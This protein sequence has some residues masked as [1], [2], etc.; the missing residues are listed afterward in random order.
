M[1]DAIGARHLSRLIEYEGKGI[2]AFLDMLLTA[3]NPLDL[4]RRNEDDGCVSPGEFLVRRLKLSHL[5]SAVGSPGS[6]YENE[7]EGLAPVVREPDSP[8][9][10]GW[11]LENRRGVTD[12]QSL[13]SAFEHGLL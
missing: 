1:V 6:A 12:I 10:R 3:E 13:G 11:Q 4:L 5:I 9:I 8:M 7:G 2:F